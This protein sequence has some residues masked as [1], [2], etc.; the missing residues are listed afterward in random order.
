MGESQVT[1]KTPQ[2]KFPPT[3]ILAPIDGSDN[4]K[5]AQAVA[6]R[7]AKDYGAELLI[8]NVIQIPTYLLSSTSIG[9]TPAIC[10]EDLFE[11]SENDARA[12]ID[13]EK[14]TAERKG[15]PKVRGEVLRSKS[16]V[17]YEIT[18]YAQLKGIDLIVIG[19]RGLGGFK[20]MVMGSVSSGV[21]THASCNVMIVK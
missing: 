11:K 15:A 7:F 10:F 19:T 21:V 20:R 18:N 1:E 6:V 16:S 4:S 8:L 12:M 13:A 17:V 3:K 14:A 2:S 9:N 5:R